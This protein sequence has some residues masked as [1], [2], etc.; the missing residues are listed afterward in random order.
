MTHPHPSLFDEDGRH[1][2]TGGGLFVEVLLTHPLPLPVR[3]LTNREGLGRVSSC[4]L[5]TC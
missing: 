4:T 1:R 3:L 5:R 2:E